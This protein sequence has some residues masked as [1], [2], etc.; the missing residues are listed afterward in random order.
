M[1]IGIDARFYGPKQ[2]GLGRYL[3]KLVEY[4][5]KVDLSNQYVIF[6]R[7]DNWNEYQ[8]SNPNFKKVLAD[9]RWYGLPEQ[10]LMPIKIW[11]AKV[12]LMHYPHF[13]VPVFCC[14]PFVVTI[15]DLV[16][17]RFP[18]RR[19][20]TLNPFLYW[21]KNLA[22]R[23]VVYL[24][25]KRA[26]K[27]IAVSDYTKKDI[28]KYF[29]AK[30]ESAS[31][32]KIKPEKIKVVYEG[33]P[34]RRDIAHRD[35]PLGT[36]LDSRTVPKGL[37]LSKSGLSLGKP[38][39]LYVGNAYPHK[40]LERLILSFKKLTEDKQMDYRLVLVGELDYF[41]QRL[42][43]WSE[44]LGFQGP[45]I[46][47]TDF[48]SDSD[49]NI[50]YQNASLYVFPSL[51]EGFGLPPLEAMAFGLPVVCSKA[52]C[53]PEILGRAALYFDPE[54]TEEM[55]DK[56]KQVLKSQKLQEELIDQG[57]KRIQKYQWSKMAQ[58]TLRIYNDANL[59]KK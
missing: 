46:I 57:F 17:R 24:V 52:T 15:H 29:F 34:A 55:A 59:Y 28:L 48:V 11:Q 1:K 39:L 2:K 10:I 45:K 6:L 44:N 38:Y 37:S 31:G 8:P 58:E 23:L 18:T 3:Q 14:Q 36:V 51:G 20:S 43:N 25:I 30:S 33:A 5:E 53:L 12:D 56:I 35:S 9:Y 41:Y 26:K 54:N 32:G 40:N 42:K 27:I 16:L 47:F 4:L 19:A 13:N 50:L 49:L 22:Y 21:L 7:R